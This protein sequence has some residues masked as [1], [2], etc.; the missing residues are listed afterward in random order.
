MPEENDTNEPASPKHVEGEKYSGLPST[1][2]PLAGLDVVINVPEVVR[3]RMVDASALE[4]Y[5]IWIF[6]ASLLASFATAFLV[7][8]IQ[9]TDPK[10]PLVGYLMWTFL[11]FA[12]LFGL[13]FLVAMRKRYLLKTKGKDIKLRTSNPVAL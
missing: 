5:E 3:V 1:E 10:S 9:A 11:A 2:N 4:E 6:V 8:W 13:A 12:V 7:A